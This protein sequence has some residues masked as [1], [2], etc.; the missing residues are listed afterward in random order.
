MVLTKNLKQRIIEIDIFRGLA[1]ITM[2]IVDAPPDFEVIYPILTHSSWQ[3]LTVADLAFPAFVFAM[4][5]S[6]SLSVFKSSF[7]FRHIISRTLLLFFIGLIFNTFPYFF[8]WMLSNITDSE[9]YEQAIINGRILGVLQRLALTYVFGILLC[10]ILSTDKNI[11]VSAFV[12]MTASS[13]GFHLYSPDDP[14]N[15]MNNISRAMDIYIFG[16]MH[17]YQYYGFPFDPENLYGTIS[18]TASMMFGVLAGRL[19]LKNKMERTNLKEMCLLGIALI[20]CGCLW[21]TFDIISKPLWTAPY[22]LLTSGISFLLI[23]L[24]ICLCSQFAASKLFRPFCAAGTNPLFFYLI[25]NVALIVLWTITFEDVP[26]YLWIWQHTT[27]DLISP[28]FGSAI[29]AF[30]WCLLWLP[31]AE[32]LYRKNIIIKL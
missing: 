19:V 13:V 28:A 8:N 18:S 31:I 25:T 12:L 15:Q 1:I 6:A 29:Y 30:I 11:L 24:I 5:M 14:F 27:K 10:R 21:S 2:I 22:T 23:A 7:H 4:G 20:I 16:E 32:L 17:L 9:L 26:V 3:G